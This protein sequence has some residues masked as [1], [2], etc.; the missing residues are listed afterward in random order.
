MMPALPHFM[1]HG[2]REAE[3]RAKLEVKANILLFAVTCALIR[4]VPK[5]IRML[6]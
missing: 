1:H 6:F 3:E 4:F 2:S 5:I